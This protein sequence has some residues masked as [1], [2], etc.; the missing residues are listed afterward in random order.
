MALTIL[1]PGMFGPVARFWNGDVVSDD[2]SKLSDHADASPSFDTKHAVFTNPIVDDA[3]QNSIGDNSNGLEDPLHLDPT[4]TYSYTTGYSNQRSTSQTLTVG[5]QQS[6]DY[7]FAGVGG[8]TTLTASG[9]FTWTQGNSED[10]TRSVSEGLGAPFD[11][12]K[13]K[14]YEE[15]LLFTQETAAVPYTT[16]IHV[17]GNLTT[18][19][20]NGGW[21]D[22]PIGRGFA[23]I[24]INPP[25]GAQ[26]DPYKDVNWRDVHYVNDNEGIFNLHGTLTLQDAGTATVKI[27]D[28]TNGGS[29]EVQA[30]YDPA[31]PVGVHRAMDDSGRTFRDTPFDDWV[32][33][34]A[35]HD[36]IHLRGGEDIAHGAGGNDTIHAA[37]VGRSLLDGGAG[38][39]VIRLVSTALYNTLHGGAGDDV[40]G[41]RAPVSMIYGGAGDDRF[42][43]REDSAGGTVITD[44]D[45]R[46]RLHIDA[47]GP[48]GFERVGQG[49]D[50][51]ILLGGGEAYDSTRDVVWVG[52][53]ATPHN[54][55]NGLG[56]AEIAALATPE[57][58]P[59]LPT[60]EPNTA[61]FLS[62]SNW[63]YS[64]DYG[65]LPADLRPFVVDGQ[66]LA[67]EVTEDGFYGAA[68][69]TPF[70]RVVVAFEGTHL[71]ALSDDPEFVLAQIAADALIRLGESPP[72][73][74]DALEFTR[75]VLEAAEAR[76]IAAGE[77]FLTGHSLGGAE[78]QYVAAQLGLAGETFGGPGIPAADIPA[79]SVSELVNYVEYGDPFG[80]YSANPNRINGFLYSDDILRYGEPTYVGDPLAVLA[81]EAAGALF[82]PGTTPEQNAEGLALIAGLAEEYHVLTTYAADLGVTLDDPDPVVNAGGDAAM[83]P[84]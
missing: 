9:S 20:N 21:W 29:Q 26:P 61:E 27:Y 67:R 24:E 72:A 52:F 32:D 82:G 73:Y 80:N 34:G 35:G 58:P 5:V 77:V 81:L 55:V 4:L 76:G 47:G 53:F 22:M 48:L 63:T 6:F 25:P 40:I 41:A 74:G 17:E 31:T 19:W 68:F 46:N 8:S 42:W 10:H 69:L 60:P 13:G 62:A 78:A 16:A 1:D 79:G 14:I 12:P 33:G 75:T 2:P 49:D 51:Y 59:P 3:S 18:N 45:G 56:A 66:H 44:A 54:R 11:I 15:K 84:A 28:I 7:E 43:L 39:D 70:D 38:D 65:D 64:R 71:S 50:L 30:E 37:S 36:R 57:P 23:L 83:L